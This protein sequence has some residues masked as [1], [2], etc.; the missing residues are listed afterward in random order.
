MAKTPPSHG[1]DPRFKSW[2]AHL[3]EREK[4][5]NKLFLYN[6]LTRKKEP[7]EPL[8]GKRVVMYVCGLTPYDEAHIGHARTYVAFDLLKRVLKY[9]GYEVYH[10]QNIT[11]VDDKIINR[12][13]ETGKHPFS[14]A[15]FYHRRALTYMEELAIEEADIYPRVSQHIQE[16]IEMIKR[17]IE[18]QYA[19]ERQGNVYFEVKKFKDYGKLSK[20]KLEELEKKRVDDKLKKSPLDFAL[21]KAKKD[22]VWWKS[23]WGE[24]RPGWHIECSAMSLKYAGR[25]TLDIHGGAKDL[26]FPHH[27]N[28]IA[29]SEAFTG[30]PFV[31]YWVHTGFLTVNGEK[32]SKSLGNFVTIKSVLEKYPGSVV[33]LFLLSAKYSSPIDFSWQALEKAK[34][35]F[36]RIERLYNALLSIAGEAEEKKAEE[37]WEKEFLSHLLNDLDTPNAFSVL[38]KFVAEANKKLEEKSLSKEEAKA[39]LSTLKK[40]LF[41]LGIKVRRKQKT[42]ISKREQ[43]LI[44][45]IIDVRDKLRKMK[46]YEISDRI[47]KS[48]LEMG[49][50]IKD[51]GDTSV[52]EL[53]S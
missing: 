14:I 47:R 33:R 27:E 39:K 35:N 12:A 13:K 41:L 10:I 8:E 21:W 6:T 11:D 25:A 9:L 52:Y 5:S 16:I 4:M 19:Y 36:E 24:G 15:D 23:P 3:R 51:L 31:K 40:M 45:L 22:L 34:Q 7:F 49:I 46:Q 50:R 32:M 42:K 37:K 43:R 2:R 44:E 53:E 20:Q 29:Q 28:E 26:I 48:L 38:Y 1:G 30:K 17:L 18:K